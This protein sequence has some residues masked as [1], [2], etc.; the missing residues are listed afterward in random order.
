LVIIIIIDYHVYMPISNAQG[1]G[2]P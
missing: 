2:T 1:N